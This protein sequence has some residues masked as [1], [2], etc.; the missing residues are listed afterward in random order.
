MQAMKLKAEFRYA[1]PTQSVEVI[2][3]DV[4]TLLREGRARQRRIQNGGNGETVAE[5]AT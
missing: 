1:R 3:R 4:A 2:G 5:E